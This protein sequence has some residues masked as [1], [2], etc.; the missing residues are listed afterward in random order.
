MSVVVHDSGR[1]R[2]LRSLRAEIDRE[3]ASEE[4]RLARI[5]QAR[6]TAFP[7]RR[8]IKRRPTAKPLPVEAS[9]APTAVIRAWALAN[10]VPVGDRGRISTDLRIAYARANPEP[11]G[12][13]NEV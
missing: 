2:K 4:A 5:D 12:S 11:A 10:G 9:T 7:V 6:Q 1:L 13:V 8:S 3:I